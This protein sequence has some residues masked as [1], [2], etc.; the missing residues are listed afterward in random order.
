MQADNPGADQPVRDKTHS[1]VRYY[2][3]GKGPLWRIFWLWGVL[4]S[5]ILFAAF[6]AALQAWG[7]TWGLFAVAAI[8]MLP[9]TAWI[10]TSVWLCA[11][12][13]GNRMWGDAARFLTF[14]WALNVGV[15]GGWLLTE[16]IL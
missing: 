13:V 10:I 15:V 4:G 7:V 5:W 2:V 11:H 16:L 12:N 8:I 14:I 3:L 9:Y 1:T 6:Y